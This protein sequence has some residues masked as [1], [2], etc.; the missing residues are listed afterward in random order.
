MS[1]SEDKKVEHDRYDKSAL[2]LIDKDLPVSNVL[3]IPPELRAPY[4]Y[5]E[6]VISKSNLDTESKILEIGA[7]TG[8]LTPIL[9]KTGASVTASDISKN[10]LRVLFLRLSSLGRLDTQIADME[11]LPFHDEVYDL[12]TSAGSLSYGD[13]KLV[14]KEVYRVLKPGGVFI[15]VD[16]LSHNPIYKLNRWV[17]YLLG[18]R[19]KSTLTRMP[20]LSLIKS[21][22]EYFGDQTVRYFGSIFWLSPVVRLIFGSKITA[23]FNDRFDQLVEVQ[24]SAFKFVMI[25]KKVNK[26]G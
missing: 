18:K 4:C 17:H 1:L 22:S 24:K 19:T 5:F 6:E 26:V 2:S 25:C 7:G 9:L 21:Y 12:V 10:S 13:N 20:T 23:L 15:C 16:S 3:N 14:M 8:A 11:S